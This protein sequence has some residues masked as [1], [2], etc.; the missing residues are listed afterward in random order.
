MQFIVDAVD[1]PGFGTPEEVNEAHQDYMDRWAD[2]LIARGPTLSPD[3]Q[4]HTGS[5][6][7]VELDD[8]DEAKHFADGEPYAMAGWYDTITITAA[9]PCLVGTMWDRPAP[10]VPGYAARVSVTLADQRAPATKRAGRLRSFFGGA[11]IS[12]LYAGMLCDGAGLG[13]GLLVLLDG[14]PAEAAV[15]VEEV[16]SR[17]GL[18]IGSVDVR[19]WRRGGRRALGAA[20]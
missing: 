20:R 15:A 12:W 13:T 8:L 7:V 4:Q 16:L 10:T 2:R 17:A 11:E 3:G 6:H 9:I 5:V 1:A 18:Q 19:R 14:R